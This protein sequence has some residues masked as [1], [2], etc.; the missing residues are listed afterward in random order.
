MKKGYDQWQKLV[1]VKKAGEIGFKEAAKV[2]GVHYTTVYEWRRE[3][4]ALGEE[5]FLKCEPRYPGRGIKEIGEEQE[6]AIIEVWEANR[7][8]G[9]GQVRSALRRQGVTVSIR[10]VRKVMEANG[11]QKR[12]KKK[13]KE[14]CQ[15]FE[16]SRPLELAQM[17]ILEVYINKALMFL[18]ILMDDFSRFILGFRLL[19][20]TSIDYV[21]GL[22]REA[23]DRYG[24]MEE[25]LTDR[26]FVFYSWRGANRFELYL[27]KERIDLT[28][29]RPHHPQTLGKVEALNRRIKSELFN[30]EHFSTIEEGFSAL[31]RW[32]D[33]Y[34]HQR[35]HEGLGGFLVP[36]ERFHGLAERV[37]EEVA[38]GKKVSN[39]VGDVDRS[40]LNVVL[41]ADGSVSLYVLGRALVL[42]GGVD[43]GKFDFG[44]G[45]DSDSGQADSTGE[46][47]SCRSERQ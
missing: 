33:H 14:A 36:A 11:Y 13:E 8:Y 28:H 24:K 27:E 22:V 34:N 38:C 1:I 45:S 31:R 37:L 2:A 10:S 19:A 29:A 16:A 40:L 21:I 23:V 4:E 43:G 46:G 6:K 18:I 3:L 30:Q 9:P 35:P 20:E 26:G 7:G 32:V 5:E 41:G 39:A 17:D 15:R 42:T 47:S 25:I 12:G 44:R